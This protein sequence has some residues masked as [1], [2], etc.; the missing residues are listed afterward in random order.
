MKR[1]WETAKGYLSEIAILM[2]K[3]LEGRY[4]LNVEKEEHELARSSAEQMAKKMV[5]EK[6]I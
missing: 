3:R 1:S 4:Q 5:K 6:E 2:G